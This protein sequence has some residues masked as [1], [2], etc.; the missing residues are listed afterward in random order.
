MA[1][2]IEEPKLSSESVHHITPDLN[3][4]SGKPEFL[5]KDNTIIVFNDKITG[6]D[7]IQS[8]K[9]CIKDKF[10]AKKSRILIICGFHTSETGAMKESFSTFHGTV[11]KHLYDLEE[12][13][14]NEIEENE[15]K[16]ESI[17]LST[18]PYDEPYVYIKGMN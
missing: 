12:Q 18:I 8:L 10:W 16:F 9:P 11:S 15:Y 2:A 5:N 4:L 13:L 14:T 17:L 7:V 1:S 6:H 3:G